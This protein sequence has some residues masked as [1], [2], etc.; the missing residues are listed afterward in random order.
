[1]TK[2]INLNLSLDET[3]KVLQALGNLPYSQ[4]S[5]LIPKIQ[6]QAQEQLKAGTDDAGTGEKA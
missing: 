6:S 3:N 5:A 1:M 2:T 4:V